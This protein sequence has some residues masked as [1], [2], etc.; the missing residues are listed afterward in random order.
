MIFGTRGHVVD[1]VEEQNEVI[2]GI[3]VVFDD[4]FVETVEHTV[5]FELALL[6]CNQELTNLGGVFIFG[7]GQLEQIA[8]GGTRE[9]LFCDF[10]VFIEGIVFQIEEGLRKLGNDGS[11]PADIAACHTGEGTT[12]LG[13][14][15]AQFE[16]IALGKVHKTQDP[17]A[18]ISFSV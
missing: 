6:E 18:L 17:F 10:E 2:S 5:V 1:V 11:I 13:Q 8:A 15:T 16:H 14:T 4:Q 7:H 12:V 3:I 9:H